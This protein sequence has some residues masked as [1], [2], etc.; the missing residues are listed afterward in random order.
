MDTPDDLMS[1]ARRMLLWSVAIL[2]GFPILGVSG[3]ILFGLLTWLLLA[4][5]FGAAPD[6]HGTAAGAVP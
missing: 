3:A 6:V 1:T 2:V 5:L 4:V